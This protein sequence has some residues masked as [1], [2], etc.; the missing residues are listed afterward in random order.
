MPA[1]EQSV[2]DDLEGRLKRYLANL[3]GYEAP[4]FLSAG[5]SAAVFRVEGVSGVRA[6][7]AFVPDFL[8]GA[9]GA[10]ERRRLDV[11]R[12]LIGHACPTLVQTFRIDEAE[13]TAFTEMEFVPWPQLT[14]KLA[15]LPDGAIVP[16]ILQL[17]EAVK[18]LETLNIVH[19]DIKPENIHVSE[20]FA[21]LKLLDLGVA[22][23]FELPDS[24]DAAITDHGNSRPFLATAQY[25]SPEYLFRLDEPTKRLWSGLNFYQLGAV[26]HDLIAKRPLFDYEMKLGNRWLVARAVLTKTPAFVDPNPNR[27]P[28]LKAL[29]ARCLV[30]DLNTRLQ[31]V[32]WDDFIL[33]GSQD[34]LTALKARLQK[35]QL[36]SGSHADAWTAG[37]LEFERTESLK[38]IISQIR[39]ELIQT[40]GKQL[41]LTINPSG[42]GEPISSRITLTVNSDTF[43]V[44]TIGIDWS[45]PP[46]DRSANITLTARLVCDGFEEQ[47]SL[48]VPRI[49]AVATISEG[50][51]LSARCIINAIAAATGVGLDHIDGGMVRAELNG[52]DLQINTEPEDYQ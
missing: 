51:E 26:L 6:F 43:I 16:L 5:G 52:M 1:L 24:E 29:S 12:R 21:N 14:G 41:P 7:K 27:L 35:G 47:V 44:C 23:E 15:T 32:G 39:T 17:V 46:Y 33:E 20:D 31:L 3:G 40:C 48:P 22:R 37:R 30:K 34:P 18:F 38:R 4:K 50:E 45:S 36:N 8:S 42:P 13:G 19:R 28:Q 25:S 10:A 2:I 9:G 49:V 11:Q